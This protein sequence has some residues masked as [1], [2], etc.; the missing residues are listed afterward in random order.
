M[1]PLL[2]EEGE[3]VIRIDSKGN[4]HVDVVSRATFSELYVNGIAFE[5]LGGQ[6]AGDIWFRSRQCIAP[7]SAETLSALSPPLDQS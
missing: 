1:K 7:Y 4:L 3:K 5:R 2:L 6:E